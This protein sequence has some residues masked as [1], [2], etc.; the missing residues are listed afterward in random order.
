MYAT[1][2]GRQFY[3]NPIT[4]ESRWKPP[5]QNIKQ[6]SKGGI[7]R[8]KVAYLPRSSNSVYAYGCEKQLNNEPQTESS[9][10]EDEEK[11]MS[12]S[13]PSTR[14]KDLLNLNRF[15]VVRD[16]IRYYFKH[17]L[18]REPVRI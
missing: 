13:L 16:S 6:P 2:T 10:S 5:R 18:L 7:A 12:R 9:S 14:P 4:G 17:S 11:V 15:S 8:G 3:F 1:P